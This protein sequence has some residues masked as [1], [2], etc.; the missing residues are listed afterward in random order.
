MAASFVDGA[1]Q[2]ALWV[3]AILLDWGGPAVLGVAEWR[4]VPAHFAERHNLVIILALGE[5]IVAIGAGADVDLTAPVVVAAVFG[6][7]LAAALWWIY[8][9]WSPW[10]PNDA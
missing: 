2:A 6:M 3:A 10:S 4:L 7:G 8:F 9:D 5:S 1:A